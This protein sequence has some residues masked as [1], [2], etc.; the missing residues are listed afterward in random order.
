MPVDMLAFYDENMELV[1]EA[2]AVQVML[3]SSSDDIRLTGQF[4]IIGPRK[5]KVGK[6]VTVCP[7][8]IE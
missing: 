2:G 4:E 8:A 5:S 1:T 6:R 3:G 7:A